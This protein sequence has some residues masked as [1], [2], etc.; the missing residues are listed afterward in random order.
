M[1][2]SN[3]TFWFLQLSKFGI[4]FNHN[5]DYRRAWLCS[6]A[7]VLIL[8][9]IFA[10]HILEF[11]ILHEDVCLALSRFGL[12]F[13]RFISW[14]PS[15][16]S[17]IFLIHGLYE[18]F[19]VLNLLLRYFFLIACIGS[20]GQ[21]LLFFRFFVVVE[22]D[23]QNRRFKFVKKIRLKS[24]SSLG[25]ST[26]FWRIWWI[27]WIFVTLFRCTDLLIAFLLFRNSFRIHTL[28]SH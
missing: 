27:N 21:S 19:A 9:C 1:R 20:H 23:F 11:F 22:I 24:S 14:N 25:V 18:R 13:L 5:R 6:M 16:L 10:F 28:K 7:A 15:V 26:P 8:L 3:S 17:F 4:Q 2:F 12:D